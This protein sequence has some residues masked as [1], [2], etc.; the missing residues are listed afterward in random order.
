MN[1]ITEMGGCDPPKVGPEDK[2]TSKTNSDTN[3]RKKRL[4]D[5]GH[6]GGGDHA[7]GHHADGHHGHHDDRNPNGDFDDKKTPDEVENEWKFIHKYMSLNETLR[8]M[9]GQTFDSFVLSCIFRGK[10]CLDETYAN[11]YIFSSFWE[12]S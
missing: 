5:N 11:I 6:H 3:V 4:A 10:D 12:I 9:I 8:E 2:S 7:D 1:D